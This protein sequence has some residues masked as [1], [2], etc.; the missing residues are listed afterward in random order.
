[1]KFNLVTNRELTE[2]KEVHQANA[3]LLMAVTESSIMF[4]S[5]DEHT[6]KAHSQMA[7]T[8]SVIVIES[9]EM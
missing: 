7:T 8:E 5:S 1:M 9:N 2:I 4:E 3:N 6:Q